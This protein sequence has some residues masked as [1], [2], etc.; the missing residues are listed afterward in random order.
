MLFSHLAPCDQ[1]RRRMR[2][3]PLAL[4]GALATTICPAVLAQENP[5]ESE[6]KQE[7]SESSS[8]KF[9]QTLDIS[10][11][12]STGE[13][14]A[15]ILATFSAERDFSAWTFFVES[16]VVGANDQTRVPGDGH[17]LDIETLELHAQLARERSQLDLYFGDVAPGLRNELAANSISG[18]GMTGILQ[19]HDTGLSFRF[20][21]VSPT[22]QTGYADGLRARN[23]QGYRNFVETVGEHKLSDE[24][25]LHWALTLFDAQIDDT[26]FGDTQEN[27]V[28]G[29][30]IMVER[31][32]GRLRYALVMAQSDFSTRNNFGRVDRSGWALYQDA[33]LVVLDEEPYLSF[34]IEHERISPSFRAI[35][36]FWSS[37]LEVLRSGVVLETESI[38][39]TFGWTVSRDNLRDDA[40]LLTTVSN[41]LRG[42]F[43]YFPD[44]TAA[45][46]PTALTLDAG[47]V[48]VR[49][50]NANE[51]LA[52]T[53]LGPTAL[54]E[55]V[56]L[57][58]GVDVEWE[59]D[60]GRVNL[61]Y[62]RTTM[63][64]RIAAR[65]EDFE[66]DRVR[67]G[68]AYDSDVWGF[69]VDAR[70]AWGDEDTNLGGWNIRD[71][72]WDFSIYYDA[73]RSPRFSARI[74]QQRRRR[75]SNG[76]FAAE[77]DA[78]TALQLSLALDPWLQRLG[79][80]Q[81]TSADIFVDTIW[82]RSEFGTN[83]RDTQDTLTGVNFAMTF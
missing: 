62:E 37:D 25:R 55:F 77:R 80:P 30:R 50:D 15:D 33:E 28:N 16:N 12:T 51:F 11:A 2:S 56:E 1:Q 69:S 68:Y 31:E 67:I 79:L 40:N 71:S 35:E 81:S 83:T 48:S 44:W 47:W 49:P 14:E 7:T 66:E 5:G 8:F 27:R 45:A 65:D 64:D 72:D 3:I 34:R 76:N 70:L 78:D 21:L 17:H 60:W 43:T 24:Y 61:G 53:N 23:F 74:N 19:S 18:R 52:T 20:G 10:G 39:A 46:A 57:Y 75:L 6:Q 22:F 32:D 41:E 82:V 29:A 54:E 73:P 58:T 13:D 4:L 36:A 9:E 38:D 26:R 42:R 59:L 63:D